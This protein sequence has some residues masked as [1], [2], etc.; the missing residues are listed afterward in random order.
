MSDALPGTDGR[1]RLY[2]MR[3]GQAAYFDADGR[4]APDPRAVGL[5]GTG[6]DQARA[7]GALLAAI[8]FDRWAHTG[9]PRTAETLSLVAPGDHARAEVLVD[10]EEIHL[11][12]V[13]A[14]PRHRVEA[15]F[16]YGLERA[17]LPEARFSGG[18]RFADFEARVVG[19]IEAVLL[20]PGWHRLLLV[21]HDAVNRMILGWATGGGL[22]ALGAFEQD[23]GCLNILDVDVIDGAIRRKLVKTQN[24]TPDNPAKLGNYLTSIEQV[25]RPRGEGNAGVKSA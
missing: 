7:M 18:E 4:L 3:H 12:T 13:A 15:E 9:M 25:A 6:R 14:M 16:V 11:G 22:S 1:R 17:A 19:G 23:A 2:L 8:A 21:A 10:L 20:A 5:T 24:L